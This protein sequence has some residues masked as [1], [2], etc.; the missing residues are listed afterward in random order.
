MSS[1]I[2]PRFLTPSLRA[3]RSLRSLP[4]FARTQTVGTR[5]KCE[6]NARK[7]GKRKGDARKREMNETQ[8][9]REGDAI[10]TRGEREGDATKN[11]GRVDGARE[12]NAGE[13]RGN[14]EDAI[15]DPCQN[16]GT[17]SRPRAPEHRNV[18]QTFESLRLEASPKL[19]QKCCKKCSENGSKISSKSTKN[20]AKIN[21]KTTPRGVPR[22]VANMSPKLLKKESVLGLILDPNSLQKSSEKQCENR[23]QKSVTK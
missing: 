11:R 17:E 23:C 7:A 1:T 8:E 13:T 21:P 3:L 9:K 2:P 10:Q 12:R 5:D 22:A 6:G 15:A 20:G 18:E 4:R 14:P 16:I 19:I